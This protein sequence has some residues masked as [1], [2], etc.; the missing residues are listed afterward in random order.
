MNRFLSFASFALPTLAG[1]VAVLWVGAGYAG[2]YPL[3]LAVTVLIGAFFLVGVAELYRYRQATQTLTGALAGLSEPAPPL[4]DWLNQIDPALRQPVRQRVEGERAGLPAPSL[5]PYLAG[6]LVLLGMLGTFAGMVVTLRGTG[7]ALQSA[8]DLAAVRAS[9]AAPVMGLGVAFGT[10]LAGVATSAMLGLLSALARRERLLAGQQLDARAATALRAYSPAFQ[11]E[12]SF[13]LMRQ[14]AEALPLLAERLQTLATQL[15]AQNGTLQERLLAGQERFHQQAESAYTGLAASVGR[16]LQDSL[17][18]SARAASAA[19]QPAVEATLAGLARETSAL[20]TS[21]SAGVQHHLDSLAQRF[22]AHNAD[23]ARH[24]QQALDGQRQ[25][26]EALTT[27]LHDTLAGFGSGFQQSSAQ[28]VDQLAAQLAGATGALAERSQALL[29]QQTQAHHAQAEHLQRQL[30]DTTTRL[31]GHTAQLLQGARQALAD[32]Q[33]QAA[34]RDA[35][36]LQAWR[37]ALAEHQRTTQA[38]GTDTRDALSATAQHFEQQV[39]SLQDGVTQAHAALQAHTAERDAQQLQAW[40]D[41]LAEH[42]RSTQALGAETRDALSGT[43]E[44]FA[45]QVGTLQDGVTQAHAALQ[46]HAA[47]RDAQQLAAWTTSLMQHTQASQDL[48]SRTQD[49]L[50]AAAAQFAEQA[51]LV[52]ENADQRHTHLRE[53]LSEQEQIRLATWQQSLTDMAAQLHQQWQQSGADGARQQQAVLAALADT[54]QT[55]ASQSATQAASTLGEINRLLDAAAAAPRAA[56]EVIGELRDKLTDSMA[57]DN[58]MLDERARALD[59]LG[60]LLER[61]NHA[62]A[63]QRQAIDQLVGGSAEVLERT[64]ARFAERLEADSTRLAEAAAHIGAGAT[65][66]ASL[67]DAFGQAVQAFGESNTLLT[68]HLQQLDDTLAKSIARSDEQLAYY[69]AQAREVIDLSLSS[70]QQIMGDLQRLARERA[71]E[72]SA[73]RG[74][75][76]AA[77]ATSTSDAAGVADAAEGAAA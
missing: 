15:E 23:V 2:S 21:V 28:L 70:Q 44:R 48:A 7:Q 45:Q 5:T 3:A 13:A 74:A 54:A 55:M 37:D 57:R 59:T 11:R 33:T 42:Q 46:A 64:A 69:V 63:E 10:S 47:E 72:L 20:Q 17:E 24:W 25:T 1:L 58:A 39:R 14:Q 65:E 51:R 19:L 60:A 56:A 49:A 41:A 26:H 71:S 35:E 50:A 68:G 36:Q 9:L 61:V 16:S 76:G 53:Q 43:A 30:S 73:A 34:A 62:S 38:L 67:G 66:I 4:A 52:N 32:S 27:R 22:D 29:A 8:T 75:A 18:G 6:L 77:G 31:A 12:A 40:R